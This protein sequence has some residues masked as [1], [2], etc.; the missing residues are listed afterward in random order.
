MKD[1]KS[2]CYAFQR[3]RKLTDRSLVSSESFLISCLIHLCNHHLPLLPDFFLSLFWPPLSLM[4]EEHSSFLKFYLPWSKPNP[5]ERF[6]T[7]RG[8]IYVNKWIRIK[9]SKRRKKRLTYLEQL[10]TDVFLQVFLDPPQLIWK[11]LH[12]RNQRRAY[13]FIPLAA[14]DGSKPQL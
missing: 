3:E 7:H 12:I 6:L 1:I 8:W 10:F 14:Y 5:N 11:S 13:N 9:E 2:H 4:F